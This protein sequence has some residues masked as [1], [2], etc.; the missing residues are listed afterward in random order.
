M[1][2]GDR[3]GPGPVTPLLQAR[4]KHQLMLMGQENPPLDWSV[5][6]NQPLDWLVQECRWAPPQRSGDPPGS[7]PSTTPG[8]PAPQE[9]QPTATP[10]RSWTE[11]TSRYLDQNRPRTIAEHSLEMARALEPHGDLE[12]AQPLPVPRNLE[13]LVVSRV[14]TFSA[15]AR[16]LALAAAATS[17]PTR[18]VLASA[19]HADADFGAALLEAE[20]AGVLTSED[21]RIRFE[22]P[23][24]ASVIYGS[25][26]AERRRQLQRLALLALHTPAANPPC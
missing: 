8:S 24:L 17:Q 12:L 4:H 11:P 9:R 26:S 10:G 2:P 15:A 3:P 19:L 6:E 21:D 5:Q 23:L 25:A 20:E 1:E 18:S 16:Q 13:E 14:A 7:P 22:H